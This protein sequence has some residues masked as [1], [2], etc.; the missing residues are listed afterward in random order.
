FWVGAPDD[1]ICNAS[2]DS[3]LRDIADLTGAMSLYHPG[4]W[5]SEVRKRLSRNDLQNADATSVS[6]GQWRRDP[7]RLAEAWR[8][9]CGY[10]PRELDWHHLRIANNEGGQH[11]SYAARPYG[12]TPLTDAEVTGCQTLAMWLQVQATFTPAHHR[13]RTTPA[14]WTVPSAAA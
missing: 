13:A 9:V 10:L 4:R 7:G 5:W 6:P 12:R 2:P 3:L 14:V 8:E 11:T 1:V